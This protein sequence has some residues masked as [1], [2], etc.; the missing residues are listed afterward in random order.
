MYVFPDELRRAYEALPFPLVFC[1]YIDGKAAPLLYTDGF[2]ALVEMER[3]RANALFGKSQF[4]RL[5]PDDVG[6]IA[7]IS[8]GFSPIRAITTSF[9]AAGTATA[10]T[11]ST[12]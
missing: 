5:H 2:C 8:A 4:E 3:S 12:P 1:Q 6:R 7:Q 10:T 11:S 9:S